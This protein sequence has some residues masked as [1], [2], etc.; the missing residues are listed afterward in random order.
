MI[1]CNQNNQTRLCE[2]GQSQSYS[3]ILL[4][5]FND[6]K[7]KINVVSL[8]ISTDANLSQILFCPNF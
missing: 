1:I 3:L 6:D 7:G 5:S 8:M 2:R 4:T